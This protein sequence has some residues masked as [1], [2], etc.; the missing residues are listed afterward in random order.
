MICASALAADCD[1]LRSEDLQ[2]G[3]AIE[4]RLRVIDPFR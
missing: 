4:R 3:L 1:T 2:D